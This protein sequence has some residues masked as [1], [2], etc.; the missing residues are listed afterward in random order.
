[1]TIQ[2]LKKLRALKLSTLAAALPLS[3]SL[4][5]LMDVDIVCT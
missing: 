3:V 2:L 5:N 1:M 4:R